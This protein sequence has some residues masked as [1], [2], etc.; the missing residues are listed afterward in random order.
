M[1][2]DRPLVRLI[3]LESWWSCD[4]QKRSLL[5]RGPI[6]ALEV[7]C[8]LPAPVRGLDFWDLA[9]NQL[10][11][12]PISSVRSGNVEA[13]E[14]HPSTLSCSATGYPLPRVSWRSPGGQRL[15]RGKLGALSDEYRDTFSIDESIIQRNSR[16][17]AFERYVY[18]FC[19]EKT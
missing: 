5:E 4:C 6:V 1:S 16:K 10:H 12:E 18:S 11:C 2:V 7:V 8:R 14:Y 3:V 17:Y 19:S 15:D 13:V 9:V